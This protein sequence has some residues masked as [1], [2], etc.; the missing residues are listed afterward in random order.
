MILLDTSFIV[1]F[2]NTKDQNHEKAKSVMDKLLKGSYG[3]FYITDYIFDE[4]A[5]VML[6]RL[7]DVEK[8]TFIG[9]DIKNIVNILKIDE[10]CFDESWKTFKNQ[11]NTL[12]SF[13]DCSTLSVMVD[14]RIIYLATFDQD[15]K[16]IKNI[17]VIDS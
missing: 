5:T 13:T 6:A 16:K 7:K 4:C 14:R 2:Y 12:L 8:T 11:K 15:F 1:S 3:E 17:N 10:N 9:E